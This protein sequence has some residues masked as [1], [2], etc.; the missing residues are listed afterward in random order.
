[1]KMIKDKM[2]K[3][4]DKMYGKKSAMPDKMKKEKMMKKT[5]K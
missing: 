2:K 1:M 4:K 3:A 5:S